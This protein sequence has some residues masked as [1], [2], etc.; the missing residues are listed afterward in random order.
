MR[1]HS[2]SNYPSEVATHQFRWDGQKHIL[3][4]KQNKANI[5]QSKSQVRPSEEGGRDGALQ[6][7]ELPT[8]SCSEMWD[9]D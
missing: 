7:D 3:N 5:D 4:Y 2:E 9:E 8:K 1:P 6:K